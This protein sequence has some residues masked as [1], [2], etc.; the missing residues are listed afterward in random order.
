MPRHTPPDA[1]FTVRSLAQARVLANPLRVRILREF[2]EAPRTTMQVAERLGEKAP[3]LYRHVQALLDAGLLVPKGERKKRGT[4]ERYLQAVASR[5]EVDAS[6]FAGKT[7]GS[8]AT[9][10]LVDMARTLLTDA[11]REI[12]DVCAD[13]GAE[14]PMLARIYVRGTAREIATFKRRINAL[15][16]GMRKAPRTPAQG[17][18]ELG[19]LIALYTAPAAGTG[20]S[21]APARI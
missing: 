6:L 21:G 9:R 20:Q 19:G 12:L 1:V 10:K 18:V 15:I 3:K 13:P 14:P 11:Q 5:F 8:A 17:A 2:V 16:D 4:T 7:P